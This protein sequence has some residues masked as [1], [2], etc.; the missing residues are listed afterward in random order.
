MGVELP[1]SGTVFATRTVI[2]SMLTGTI[3]TL[4]ASIVPARRATRVA[5]ISAVREGSDAT[6]AA[7]PERGPRR[8]II[9]TGL[10]LALDRRRPVRR[11][12]AGADPGR[13]GAGLFVGIA[14]LARTWSSRSP[15]SSAS[16]GASGRLGGP[17]RP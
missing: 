2:V 11:R 14:M 4:V 12:D 9:V 13:R 5:P 8:G 7:G 15:R 17:A 10:A 1:K 6:T 16:R 3:V